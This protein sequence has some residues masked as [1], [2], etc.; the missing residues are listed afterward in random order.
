M[1]GTVIMLALAAALTYYAGEEI[2]RGVKWTGHKLHD[3]GVKIVHVLKKVP[4]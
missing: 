3:G 1:N 4:H 2:V